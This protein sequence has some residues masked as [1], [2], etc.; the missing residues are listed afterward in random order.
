MGL[1]PSSPLG[2]TNDGVFSDADCK[3]S[4]S[5]QRQSEWL[6]ALE[7][8]ASDRPQHS[9]A[10]AS[11]APSTSFEAPVVSSV[12]KV[13]VSG[14]K[15]IH[16]E[17]AT[18]SDCS[19]AMATFVLRGAV[20]SLDR[21]NYSIDIKCLSC[22]Q[23][24]LTPHGDS[25]TKVV[26]SR[27]RARAHSDAVACD[28]CRRE[29]GCGGVRVSAK[30]QIPFASTKQD[31]TV[32]VVCAH[33][34]EHFGF[35]TECGGGGKYRTGKYRPVEL[36]S[37]GRRT[38]NLSHVR[39]GDA[40]LAYRVYDSTS[41]HLTATV[42]TES[43]ALL[44]EGITSLLACPRVMGESGNTKQVSSIAAID[45]A[46]SSTWASCLTDLSTVPSDGRKRMLAACFM[47]RVPRKKSR[48]KNQAR[49]VIDPQADEDG[50][51]PTSTGTNDCI[52][53][54]VLACEYN[55]W[56]GTI[57]AT[58][59]GCHMMALQSTGPFKTMLAKCAAKAR[60]SP[61]AVFQDVQH[62]WFTVPTGESRM[63]AFV[64]KLGA[65]PLSVYLQQHSNVCPSVFAPRPEDQG[66]ALDIFA[67][68]VDSL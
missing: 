58:A 54:A 59:M 14:K 4:V 52:Q 22:Q 47:P 21:S 23:N 8:A 16:E 53:T 65:I 61:E 3:V 26:P 60:A 27:K 56:N 38:C 43:K 50:P 68:E 42:L 37:S 46:V 66:K 34:R 2:F 9:E 36:F 12:F 30:R 6:S 32:E 18:C 41:E 13:S 51:A 20:G 57:L 33:C 45:A 10:R 48:A 17:P 31:F 62:V 63:A 44:A 11:P 29:L 40:Q 5:D 35:C 64:Q 7:A 55:P 15:V 67:M 25:T 28:V 19:I 1:S 49:V 24:P 39:V